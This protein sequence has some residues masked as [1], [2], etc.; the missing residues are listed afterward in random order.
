MDRLIGFDS[1][2]DAA[3]KAERESAIHPAQAAGRDLAIPEL[4]LALPDGRTIA[5]I[6]GLTFRQGQRT[7]L[8]GSIRLGEINAVPGYL[9]HLA[10]WP[11]A[12]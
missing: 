12:D 8:V 1:S 3:H 11:G 5:R 9:R 4:D 7:Q 2:I 10:L 6:R